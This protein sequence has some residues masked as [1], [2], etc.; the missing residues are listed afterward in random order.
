[1]VEQR[2]FESCD[3]HHS[4]E[5]GPEAER[6]GPQA[7]LAL[8]PADELARHADLS[9]LNVEF[10]ERQYAAAEPLDVTIVHLQIPGSLESTEHPVLHREGVISLLWNF[11]LP[12][13]YP[14]LFRVAHRWDAEHLNAEG[15]RLFTDHLVRRI[16]EL[17][18]AEASPA[19]AP[20]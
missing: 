14:E 2:G 7:L 9:G 16:A 4:A 17:V 12:E 19:G 11:N 20:R 13:Q 1:L 6:L 15:V 3:E 8:E 5:F 10:Y 18:E